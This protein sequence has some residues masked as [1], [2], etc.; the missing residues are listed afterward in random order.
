MKFKSLVLLAI[1]ALPTVVTAQS[2][3]DLTEEYITNPGFDYNNANGWTYTSNA[4]SQSVNHQTMEFWNGTFNIYQEKSVPNGKYRLYVQAYYRTTDNSA[5]YQ[6]YKNG[7]E[8]ITTYLYANDYRTKVASIYSASSTTN[9]A[10]NCWNG[11]NNRN[12]IYF[13]NGMASASEFFAMGYYE[14]TLEFEVTDN[15]LKFGLI[16]ETYTNSNWCMFDNFRL[17][18]YGSVV[19]VSSIKLSEAS[20]DLSLGDKTQLQATILPANATY[21][22]LEWSSDDTEVVTVDNNGNVAAVGKGTATITVSSVKHPSKYA[23]CKVNVTANTEGISSLIINEIQSSNIDMYV[24]PSFNYGGWIELYNPTNKAVA[25]M[26]LYVSDDPNNLKKFKLPLEAGSVPAKGFRNIWFDHYEVKYSQVNFKLDFDGG[27]IYLSDFD[28]NLITSQDYPV[29]VPR[30]SY[31]RT[32]NGGSSWGLTAEPTPERS[33]ASSTFAVGRLAAP[34]VDKDAQLF[35][36]PFTVSVNIPSGATLRYT[37]D[38]STPTLENG[39]TSQTGLFNVSSTTT[40]RFRLFKEGV[41]PSEVITR[42]YL[43]QDRDIVLPVISVVTDPVNLFSDSL[44]IYVRGVNGR[45]GNGQSSP[46]NWNMDWDRPVNF[47][48]IVPGE[49]MVLNQEVD[50]S[51][52]GGWSRAWEPHSFKLKATKIYEGRNSMDYTFFEDKQYLKHKT[53]QIRNGGNDTGSR[54]K[55]AALQE[56]V[57]TSGINIDGQACQ[58]IVHFINGEYKGML[59]MREPNNKHFAYA[60]YGYDSDEIDQFEMSPDSGYCQKEGS[61][62]SFLKWYDLSADAED[63]VVYEEICNMVDIDEYINYMAVEFYLGATDWPQNNVKGFKPH[64]DGGKFR[65]VLFDLDGTFGTLDPFNV[66][67]GKQTYRFDY[68]YTVNGYLTEEIEFV[69][70]FLNMLANEDFVKKFVDTY[71]LVAG[72]VF[73]PSRCSEII[74]AMAERTYYTLQQ[75]GQNPYNTA[76]GLINSLNNRQQTM[77][78]ALKNYRSFNIYGTEE[79]KVELSSNIDV[80]RISVN[81]MIVPTNKFAGSLFSPITLK[82]SAPANYKF[83]GWRNSNGAAVEMT[84]FEKGSAWKYYDQGS[85]DGENWTA[86]NYSDTWKEGNSPLGYYTSDANNSRGYNTFLDYGSDSNNKRPTYYFRKNITLSTTP[87][88]SDI[89][90]L[91]YTVDD[92]MV[93]YVNGVEAARYLM[94]NGEVTY[95]TFASTYANNN[96][97]SGQLTLPAS[98]FK[99]GNNT[100]AVEIHN[101][102]ASSSDIY[103][104]A[105]LTMLTYN[106]EDSFISHDEEFVMPSSGNLSLIACYEP[107]TEE[108]LGETYATPV[109]INEI[110][111]SNSVYVNEYFEKNDWIELY[112]TTSEDF[113]IAGMYLSDN[114]KKPLKYQIP[115][116]GTINTVIKPNG[117]MVIWADKLEPISQLHTSFKLGA[118]GGEVVLTSADQTWC[119][120]LVYAAHNGDYSVGLFPDGGAH[121]YIMSKPTIAATNEINFYSTFW[122]EPT[123]ENA[124]KDVQITRNG[125]LGLTYAD[126]TVSIHSEK[127]GSA[128]VCIYALAGQTVMEESI[129]LTGTAETLSLN[130]LPDGTYIVKATD[131]NGNICTIKVL[132]Q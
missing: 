79:Q 111:A 10:N 17:E 29:A 106:G 89:F 24:D 123:I 95:N 51:M 126:N 113:D 32:T 103:F 112:N 50:M 71:C 2:W 124:I 118:E 107:L 72:S 99:R 47:E 85:L 14:N 40:Y 6:N 117:Y 36:A 130:N 69:T 87:T 120:T 80:A 76:N 67:A 91:N 19:N 26:G 101:N 74:N 83:L 97:D 60:N 37:V 84:L 88:E 45:P 105:A 44:G 39:Y 25:L 16:N 18:Y 70:I 28:G 38:G 122:D 121:A 59:N 41:L 42:S 13:P 12:P 131:N 96:P 128:N 61:K 86:N 53:L 129:S 81:D 54:I 8:N 108:E 49:G 65:F 102:N 15:H 63:P 62:E 5:A 66:F 23:T 68:N 73:T 56:I 52:C 20:L 55:D 1:L 92:G 34:I 22:D 58:P 125:T 104:D 109:K 48:Y 93:V 90:T 31:A 77:I 27:V 110:C 82:A 116:D 43:Y 7:N 30:T 100:I 78:N 132:K 98:L 11:G 94:N 114:I 64:F 46:C 75:E 21:R 127:A 3:I 9:V 4:S 57:R 119:D 33:N 35:S 115:T